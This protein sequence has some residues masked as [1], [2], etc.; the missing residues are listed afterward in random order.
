MKQILL[1]L[2]IA[3]TITLSS[4]SDKTVTK[5]LYGA[6][7][8]IQE[9]VD[10]THSWIATDKNFILDVSGKCEE[11]AVQKTEK[12]D[13]ANPDIPMTDAKC[14]GNR[15]ELSFTDTYNT[16][17]SYSLKLDASKDTLT[18]TV[19]T[20]YTNDPEPEIVKIRFARIGGN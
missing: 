19:S 5:T 14:F 3:A 7:D 11:I 4:C 8:P 17:S 20:T 10:S 15:D 1:F 16:Q 6:W 12:G 9:Y 18:G 13:L 2:F